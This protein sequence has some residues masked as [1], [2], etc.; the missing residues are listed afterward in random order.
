MSFVGNVPSELREMIQSGELQLNESADEAQDRILRARNAGIEVEC[1]LSI[2]PALQEVADRLR[3]GW[4]LAGEQKCPFTGF[5]LLKYGRQ[6][7]SVRLQADVSGHVGEVERVEQHDASLLPL[8]EAFAVMDDY[9]SKG[10]QMTNEPCP[11]SNFPLIKS[12]D[13]TRIWSVRCQMEIISEGAARQMQLSSSPAPTQSVAKPEEKVAEK[14]AA[15]KS[16]VYAKRIGEKLLQG[17]SLLQ[18]TCPVS[19]ECPLMADTDGRQW[20][21][22]LNAYLDDYSPRAEGG[23]DDAAAEPAVK[24]SQRQTMEEMPADFSGLSEDVGSERE[25][26]NEWSKKMG[27]MLCQGWSMSAELCPWTKALPLMCKDGRKYSVA[28]GKYVE[29]VEVENA[30]AKEEEEEEQVAAPSSN[31]AAHASVPKWAESAIASADIDE[32]E[33]EGNADGRAE[34]SSSPKASTGNNVGAPAEKDS[35][36]QLLQSY[37]SMLCEKVR[38]AMETLRSLGFT[39]SDICKS[40]ELMNFVSTCSQIIQETEQQISNLQS[41]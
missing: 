30:R 36:L 23:V 20:S 7:W 2:G 34:Q 27:E 28:A 25:E 12:P 17:W 8:Q 4:A 10:W 26:F 13:G 39:T 1:L 14:S 37:H 21:P 15:E 35:S 29:E 22:A 32:D 6:L 9:L 40:K 41:V 3:R 24:K 31:A 5:P 11:V 19:M 18:E 16:D 33:L 38:A